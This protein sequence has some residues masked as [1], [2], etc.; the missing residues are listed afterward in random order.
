MK[1]Q[2]K[3]SGVYFIQAAR[4]IK[5]GMSKNVLHRMDR[6]QTFNPYKLRLL[7]VIHIAADKIRGQH[8]IWENRIHQRFRRYRVHKEWFRIQGELRGFL[9]GLVAMQSLFDREGASCCPEA[10]RFEAWFNAVLDGS[11]VRGQDVSLRELVGRYCGVGLKR[12]GVW[13]EVDR[14]FPWQ[15]GRNGMIRWRDTNAEPNRLG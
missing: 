13:V 3:F 15:E 2:P 10:P 5:I 14:H 8:N 6:I 11:P 12:Q 9:I 7:A 4:H 1:N